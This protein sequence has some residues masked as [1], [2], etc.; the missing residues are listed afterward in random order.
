MSDAA[1][2][3]ELTARWVADLGRK[4]QAEAALR[5][6]LARH[7]EP[8]RRYHTAVHVAHVLR[9]VA[10]LGEAADLEAAGA[11]AVRLAAWYHDAVYDPRAGAGANEEASAVLAERALAELG[12]PAT[13]VAEVAR[14]VRLTAGHAPAADDLAGAV[15]V[16][17]DLGVLAAGPA[18]Y[19][20]Y[21]NGVRTEYDHVA[22]EAWRTG[23]AAVLQGFLDRA[24]L[25]HL[26]VDP[27]RER[28]AR[29]NLAAELLGLTGSPPASVSGA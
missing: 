10:V 22:D 13:T 26:A 4:G 8:H 18:A 6:L 1:L 3:R 27:D 25:F 16:D 28:R 20:A 19:Q 14:L 24:R 29:A 9:A 23:R 17:A 5:S 12:E 21:V 15:L 7:A 11:R 2:E